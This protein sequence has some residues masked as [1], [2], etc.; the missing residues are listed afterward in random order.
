MINNFKKPNLNA[1]RYRQKR[2]GI[3]NEE[4]YREFKDKKPLYSEIDNKKLKLIIKTYN[5]NLWKAAISNRDGVELPD[6]L[7]YLFIGHVLI[8]NLLILIM[9]CQKNMARSYR[10]K[11]GKRMVI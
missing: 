2:L 6:S 3:L 8:H 9:L 1:P 4:T 5:E 10:I 11:I 7:G